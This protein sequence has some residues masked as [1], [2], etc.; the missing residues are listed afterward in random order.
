MSN[1]EVSSSFGRTE[2]AASLLKLLSDPMPDT[3]ADPDAD[4]SLCDVS[5]DRQQQQ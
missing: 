3:K 4:S 1:A 2:D 5:L